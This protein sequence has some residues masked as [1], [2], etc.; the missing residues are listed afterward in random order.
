MAV[1]SYSSDVLKCTALARVIEH[2]N[3]VFDAAIHFVCIAITGEVSGNAVS[4]DP[5]DWSKNASHLADYYLGCKYTLMCI[6]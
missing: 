1:L 5:L 2:V 6:R 3:A 4:F